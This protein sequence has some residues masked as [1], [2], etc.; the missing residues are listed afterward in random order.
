MLLQTFWI[1]IFKFDIYSCIIRIKTFR[2]IY[3]VIADFCNLPMEAVFV[4]C[5]HTHTGPMLGKDLASD[6]CGNPIYEEFLGLQMRDAA[7]LALE[8][9]CESY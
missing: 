6:L 9:V 7:K 3:K 4:N 5:S 1:F 2:R 8:D